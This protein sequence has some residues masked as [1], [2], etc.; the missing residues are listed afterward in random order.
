MVGW[1]PLKEETG[2]CSLPCED[3]G[4]RQLS[5]NQEETAPDLWE[6]SCLVYGIAGA[7]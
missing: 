3:T 6:R 4:R 1:V 5:V 7:A 2:T